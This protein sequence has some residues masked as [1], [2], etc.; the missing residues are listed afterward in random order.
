[1]PKYY[2]T[3]MKPNFLEGHDFGSEDCVKCD[4]LDYPKKC[5]CGGLIHEIYHRELK[6]I[7]GPILRI[8]YFKCD[9]CGMTDLCRESMW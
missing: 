5:G 8:S 2:N 7:D 6:Y 4:S 1:M 9:K 3:N